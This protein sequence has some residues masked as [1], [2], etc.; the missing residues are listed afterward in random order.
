[1]LPGAKTRYQ[2]D[3]YVNIGREQIDFHHNEK[4]DGEAN[5]NFPA[6][7]TD[8][9][10]SEGDKREAQSYNGQ[11]KRASMPSVHEVSPPIQYED[12]ESVWEVYIL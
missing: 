9:S 3:T 6:I 2:P 11:P 10:E 1:M 7:I 12:A 8:N 5:D 4:D